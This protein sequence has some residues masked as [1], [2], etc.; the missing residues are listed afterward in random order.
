MVKSNWKRHTTLT[1]GLYT[2][3]AHAYNWI[4]KSIP[5]SKYHIPNKAKNNP[6]THTHFQVGRINYTHWLSRRGIWKEEQQLFRKIKHHT[7][8]TR[9]HSLCLTDQDRNGKC[10]LRKVSQERRSLTSASASNTSSGVR[11]CSFV[12]FQDFGAVVAVCTEIQDQSFYL[13][14]H[15]CWGLVDLKHLCILA[16][17]HRNSPAARSQT[18]AMGTLSLAVQL[19]PKR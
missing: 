5:I 13:P 14:L 6:P 9:R 11:V 2:P 3:N 19:L 16:Q 7:N 8:K 12:F 15:S 17:Q 1:S 10:Y 4:H 18:K